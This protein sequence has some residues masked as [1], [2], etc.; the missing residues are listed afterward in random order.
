MSYFICRPLIGYYCVHLVLAWYSWGCQQAFSGHQPKGEITL[1]IEGMTISKDETLT[2]SQ[3][4]NEL[5]ELILLG[6]SLFMV[7]AFP[8]VS[9]F[10]DPLIRTNAYAMVPMWDWAICLSLRFI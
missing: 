8:I 2:E 3:L 4:E 6:H 5:K 10:S 9:V 1:L 7:M